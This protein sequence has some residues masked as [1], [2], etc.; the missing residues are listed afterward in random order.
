[1]FFLV[2]DPL[3]LEPAKILGVDEGEEVSVQCKNTYVSAGKMF[4][5]FSPFQYGEARKVS[6][7]SN[8]FIPA[9]HY[10]NSGQYYCVNDM[11]GVFHQSGTFISRDDTG[12]II[13][14][15]SV[16]GTSYSDRSEDGDED[17]IDENRDKGENFPTDVA[18][19]KIE[20]LIKGKKVYTI[21]MY[22]V[23]CNVRPIFQKTNQRYHCARFPM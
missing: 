4:W 6:Y 21:A 10:Y 1:M 17:L 3:E 16:D 7:N 18:T 22:H 5:Y 12:A 15:L 19:R 23:L 8:L 11:T 2:L 9:M 14:V 20:I 13:S